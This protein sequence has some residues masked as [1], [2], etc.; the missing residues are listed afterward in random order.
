MKYEIGCLFIFLIFISIFVAGCTSN[1]T[2][3]QLL[4]GESSITNGKTTDL[5]NGETAV[6]TVKDFKKSIT[7][8]YNKSSET[9]ETQIINIGNKAFTDSESSKIYAVDWGGV[10]YGTSYI[11]NIR[12]LVIYPGETYSN[13]IK[14]DYLIVNDP[15]GAVGTNKKAKEGKM[16]LYVIFG[17]KKAS[18]IITP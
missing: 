1:S 7:V 17:D 16:T 15:M 2:S 18:W 9:V 14:L 5:K 13:D 11:E 8:Y 10:K 4:S 6:L 3:T 12:G